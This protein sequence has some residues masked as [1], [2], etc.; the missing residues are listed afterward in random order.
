[1]FFKIPYSIQDKQHSFKGTLSICKLR[2]HYHSNYNY[3]QI[4]FLEGI[5]SLRDINNKTI[6][7]ENV[8]G[9]NAIIALKQNL[10]Q[11]KTKSKETEHSVIN[12][13]SLSKKSSELMIVNIETKDKNMKSRIIR[14]FLSMK[15]KKLFD[16]NEDYFLKIK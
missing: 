4:Y 14:G 13:D 12:D 2:E 1:M 11:E 8:K 3:Y 16:E 15:I 9:A 5:V 7:Q 10:Q 6:Y